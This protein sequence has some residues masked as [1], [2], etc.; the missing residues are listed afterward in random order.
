MYTPLYIKTE[1]SLLSSLIKIDDLIKFAKQNNI[2]SLTITDNKL[3][4]VYEFYKKCKENNIKPI[5]GLEIEI[6]E[7]KIILYAKNQ[8]GYKNLLKLSKY[9]KLE[10]ELLNEYNDN[11]ICILPYKSLNIYEKIK[12]IYMDIFIGYKNQKKEENKNIENKKK[13]MKYFTLKKKKK[14]I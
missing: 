13:K 9:D 5:I 4:G 12:K 10:L 7:N 2:K 6:D 3:Y 11:L 14:T 8:K 1:N